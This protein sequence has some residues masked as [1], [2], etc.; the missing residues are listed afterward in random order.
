MQHI[1][2]KC[3]VPSLS[4]IP[5]VQPV[6]SNSNNNSHQITHYFQQITAEQC[7]AIRLGCTKYS[8]SPRSPGQPLWRKTLYNACDSGLIQKLPHQIL[9]VAQIP[10]KGEVDL[11]GMKWRCTT[12]LPRCTS[13]ATFLMP[14]SLCSVCAWFGNFSEAYTS[15]I[16]DAVQIPTN[17][18]VE[19]CRT[20][21]GCTIIK[22]TAAS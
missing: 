8:I 15:S 7:R 18:E 2:S 22:R 13:S 9:G 20:K 12:R 1:A 17:A 14:E 19:L 3:V 4:R 16:M 10:T 5:V 21:R 6:N 11:C